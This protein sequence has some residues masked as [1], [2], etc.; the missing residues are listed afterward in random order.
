MPKPNDRVQVRIT[1]PGKHMIPEG[2][3]RQGQVLWVSS[4][5]AENYINK[6]KI[7]E[8]VGAG[9]DIQDVGPSETKPAEAAE[10]K[11]SV[12]GNQAGRSTDLATSN[13][14]GQERSSASPP[15]PASTLGNAGVFEKPKRGRPKKST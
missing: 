1:A 4:A 10:K 7:A 13:E 3:V 12:G 11:E 6:F 14:P 2:Y 15:A 9:I 8:P 5:N